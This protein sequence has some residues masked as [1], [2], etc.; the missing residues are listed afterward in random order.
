MI[1]KSKNSRYAR[2][3]VDGIL[4]KNGAGS[5]LTSNGSS[6][7]MAKP[8]D[9][10]ERNALKRCERII[11]I[12]AAH[13]LKVGAALKEIRDRKLYREHYSSFE[14][15]CMARFNIKRAHGYR[16][17][18]QSAAIL[19]LQDSAPVGDIPLPTNERQ[20]RELSQA[21]PEMRLAVMR[22]A[23][24]MAEGK[25]FTADL[26][27]QAR[28]QLSGAEPT[29]GKLVRGGGNDEVLTPDWLAAAIVD[30][31]RPAGRTCEPCYGG[32]AFAKCM[33][34]CDSFDLGKGEDF[35]KSKNRY[36]PA[37]PCGVGAA[38]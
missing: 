20:A 1:S 33:P 27:C 11:K 21:P 28:L 13:F 14:H 35:L 17:I 22:L 29:N 2:S 37:A 34:G 7:T 18:E 16:L 30:H 5:I 3:E 24:E 15:Y 23:E 25:E 8:L 31:F 32:G 36:R 4:A 6:L 9:E 26:I 38:S 10:S 19:A 12:G